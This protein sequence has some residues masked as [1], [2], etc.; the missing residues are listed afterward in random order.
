SL[1][2]RVNARAFTI[3]SDVAFGAGEYQPG[4][5]IGDALIAHELAH[6]VQQQGNASALAPKSGGTSEYNA[7]E[8]DAEASA[9]GA[10]AGFWLQARNGL[11]AVKRNIVPTLRAGLQLQRCHPQPQLRDPRQIQ[12]EFETAQT[13]LL[14]DVADTETLSDVRLS[15]QQLQQIYSD[16]LE[17]AGS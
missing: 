16:A 17:D 6:V 2:T 13:Q 15:L 3:G 11:R 5:L 7:L 14:A 9:V 12:H 1:S 4:T 8:E 10:T